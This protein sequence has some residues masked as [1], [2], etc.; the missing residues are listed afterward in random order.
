MDSVYQTDVFNL[1]ILHFMDVN[2][3]K[4]ADVI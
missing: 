2:V 1:C 3:K 4:P